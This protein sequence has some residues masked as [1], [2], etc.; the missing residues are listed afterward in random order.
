MK[1]KM[2]S[3]MNA[4]VVERTV[5]GNRRKIGYPNPQNGDPATIIWR[6]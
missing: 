1:N 6:L 3:A 4:G 5:L 2:E